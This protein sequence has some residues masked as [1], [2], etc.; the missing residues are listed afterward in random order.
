MTAQ[1]ETEAL[2][3]RV[4]SGD[5]TAFR[6]L[7]AGTAPKLYGIALRILK[8]DTLA[9]EVLEEVF[10]GVW[11]HAGQYRSALASPVTWLVTIT[12]DA[13]VARLNAARASGRAGVPLD[14]T[15]RLY[16]PRPSPE[17]L[18]KLREEARV[19]GTCLNELGPGRAE[20]LRQAYMYGATYDDLA[21]G[22]GVTRGSLRAALRTD[23]IH[24]RDC[25]S[26]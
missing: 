18:E 25:L 17:D 19:L 11:E 23:L 10:V 13:A 8:D 2:L 21:E 22:A 24:L 9:E 4:A 6:K 16:A 3:G 26:R 20:M 15:E 12:R 1:E 7:Y 5:R 14:I